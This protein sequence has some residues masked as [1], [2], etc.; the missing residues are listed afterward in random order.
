[1]LEFI[2][3]I[4]AV[5]LGTLISTA[6]TNTFFIEGDHGQLEATLQMPEISAQQ[7]IRTVIVMHGL[8]GNK[9]G[10]FIIT[11]CD[12]LENRG[13]ATLRFD[14]NGHGNSDGEFSNM[15]IP[16]EIED[17]KHVYSWL[18]NQPWVQNIAIWGHSQGALVGALLVGEL[19]NKCISK[20]VL[21]SAATNIPTDAAKGNLFGYKFN[22]NKPPKKMKFWDGKLLG[23][24]YLTTAAAIN[25]P[26][27]AKK[28]NGPVLLIHGDADPAVPPTC[29]E[30]LHSVFTNS[31]LVIVPDANHLFSGL[32]PKMI[33]PS[34]QFL[35]E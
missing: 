20:A 33:N 4:L 30:E 12:S 13:I 8:T 28:Y 2:F 9:D 18:K 14:F 23:R 7:K 1:M 24:D 5:I 11:L 32:L 17:A 34:L 16:N 21:V 10:K 6:K 29:S 22:P 3:S 26:S 25:V 19:G 15:T 31:H 27:I 35:S